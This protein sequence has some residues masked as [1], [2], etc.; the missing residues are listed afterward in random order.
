M[1]ENTLP[2]APAWVRW[3]APL[4][5]RLPVGRYRLINRM[6]RRVPP[7]FLARLPR[8]LGG[9]TFRCDLRDSISREACF[10]GRYE[11][12]ETALVRAILRPG[13]TFVDVGANWG[14]FTLLAAYLVGRTGRV[15]SLE[16]DPRLF[17]LLEANLVDN[18]LSQ[19]VALQLAAAAESG[20]LPLA[21]Y[22]EANGNFGLSRVVGP[23]STYAK[24]FPIL[25]RPLDAVL[26]EVGLDTV[27]LMK[28]DIEGAEGLALTGLQNSLVHRRIQRLLLELHPA[29]LLEHGGCAGAL[30]SELRNYGY[31]PWHIDHSNAVSRGV[32]YKKRIDPRTILRPCKEPDKLD[33]WPHMLWTL[34]GSEQ[35]W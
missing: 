30:I 34:P 15:L 4:I 35:P 5:R 29:Q 21:G 1:V 16:P 18:R 23:H 33:R 28:M 12:Q 27:H 22:D 13:M 9:Y 14:Y 25:A 7:A 11:P 10:T 8:E 24:S 31:H 2:G 17:P 32:A 26:S 6:C 3:V 19:V 20:W